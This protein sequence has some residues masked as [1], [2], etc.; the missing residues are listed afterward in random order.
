MDISLEKYG[1]RH[2]KDRMRAKDCRVVE[3]SPKTSGS[4]MNHDPQSHVS[5]HKKCHFSQFN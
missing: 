4:L 5:M 3:T 2:H 1:Q